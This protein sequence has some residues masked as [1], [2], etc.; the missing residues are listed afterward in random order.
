MKSV[1][2]TRKPWIIW[3]TLGLT[4]FGVASRTEAVDTPILLD[5]GTQTSPVAD[6]VVRVTEKATYDPRS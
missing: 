1:F 5:L 6:L 3:G 4:L 2:E